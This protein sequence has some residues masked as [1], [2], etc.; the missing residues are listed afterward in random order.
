MNTKL[1]T[2]KQLSEVIST[3]PYTI[4]KLVR[5]RKLPAYKLTGKNYLFDIEEILQIIKER[6]VH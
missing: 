2:V 5:E 1:L 4:R 3:P 6:S